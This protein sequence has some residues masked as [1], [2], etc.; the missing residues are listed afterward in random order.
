VYL[1]ARSLKQYAFW[2]PS[3]SIAPCAF[4]PDQSQLTRTLTERARQFNGIGSAPAGSVP[5]RGAG[6]GLETVGCCAAAHI[7]EHRRIQIK[8][9]KEQVC[10]LGFDSNSDNGFKFNGCLSGHEFLQNKVSEFKKNCVCDLVPVQERRFY[11][12]DKVK[13]QPLSTSSLTIVIFACDEIF[14]VATDVY[15][16]GKL[17]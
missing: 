1:E 5:A 6:R 16:K 11:L 7:R 3:H 13:K 10:S 4:G 8:Y 15:S 9:L 12:I 14:N 17:L 2:T